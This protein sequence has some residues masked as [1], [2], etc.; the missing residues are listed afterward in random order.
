MIKFPCYVVT[1]A[2][3]WAIGLA[4]AQ[5]LTL[6]EASQVIARVG[7]EEITAGDFARDLQVR[8]AQM[9]ATTGKEVQADLRIRRAL[10]NELIQERVLSIASRN[11]D[12]TVDDAA[13]EAEFKERKEI[14]DSEEAYEAYLDALR[15]TEAGLKEHMRA[16]LRIKAF[17]DRET[18]PIEA[19]DAEIEEF[20]ALMKSQGTMT[21]TNDTRDIA[22][23]LFR[24]KGGTDESWRA[25]EERATAARER[26]AAG[27]VFAELAKELS[28]DPNTAPDGGK[29][30]EMQV[31]SFY[32]ELEEAMS[33]LPIGEVSPPVRSVMGW[34]LITILEENRPGIVPLEKVS[35]MIA[36]QIVERERK[37][38][39][40]E[41]VAEAQ[42]LIRVEIV[43]TDA[44]EAE[45]D[46]APV[47]Q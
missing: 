21:R 45:A 20:Y 15:L 14:F 35:D 37:A 9:K 27:E 26:L 47:S 5:E 33:K 28:E 39:V 24:A 23:I 16:R 29:L 30:V 3:V 1:V 6:K 18:G 10:M 25:A 42:K 4:P 40:K 41:I 17:I 34:Y 36:T 38:K 12:V 32:P 44:L 2:L 31:G 22:V 11:A 46:V 7:D 13:L 43:K 8:L 19:S